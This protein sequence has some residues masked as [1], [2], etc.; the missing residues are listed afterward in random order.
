MDEHQLTWVDGR[1]TRLEKASARHEVAV[2]T[3]AELVPEVRRLVKMS[4][5]LLGAGILAAVLNQGPHWLSGVIGLL[6][7]GVH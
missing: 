7:D 4:Y 1:L 3:L 6:T 2:K 5:I